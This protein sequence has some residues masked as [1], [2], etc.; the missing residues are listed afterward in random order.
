MIIMA[1][2]DAG[3][4]KGAEGGRREAK[5]PM[6]LKVEQIETKIQVPGREDGGGEGES[7]GGGGGAPGW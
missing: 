5:A 2:T 6:R 4:E 1:E 7:R 3:K